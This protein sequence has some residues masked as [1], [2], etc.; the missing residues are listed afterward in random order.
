[1]KLTHPLLQQIQKNPP[2]A[3]VILGSGL[4]S[5]TEHVEIQFTIPYSEIE[6]FPAVTVAGH[7]GELVAGTLRGKTVL[8]ARGR[9]HHYEGYAMKEILTLVRLF[10]ELGIPDLVV[11]NAAGLINTQYGVGDILFIRDCIDFTGLAPQAGDMAYAAAT[12]GELNLLRN[13]SAALGTNIPQG[14]YVWTTGPSYETPAEIRYMAA[15][16]GDLV[17]MSTMPEIIFA[18]EAGMRVFPFSCATNFA[19]GISDRALSH[20]EVFET[21]DRVKE[22]LSGIVSELVAQL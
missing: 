19:A 15:R 1:M 22:K 14:V 2:D 8:A 11:T 18:R 21:A 16:G 10:S 9:F 3:A 13:V 6:G 17:G 7:H 20:E 5:F 4:G 12:D